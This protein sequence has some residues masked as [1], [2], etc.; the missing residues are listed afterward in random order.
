MKLTSAA[1]GGIISLTVKF[2][3]QRAILF[4]LMICICEQ[5]LTLFAVVML[6]LKPNNLSIHRLTLY[7]RHNNNNSNITDSKRDIYYRAFIFSTFEI[8]IS[9]GEIDTLRS[10]KVRPS[11]F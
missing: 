7:N 3:M 6:G 10:F 5:L 4:S 9:I 11:T 8:Q 2:H 1:I